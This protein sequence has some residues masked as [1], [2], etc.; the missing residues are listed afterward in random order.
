M[1]H[2]GHKT[3]LRGQKACKNVKG[4]AKLSKGKKK[5]GY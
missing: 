1:K 4:S 3:V 5:K 2:K